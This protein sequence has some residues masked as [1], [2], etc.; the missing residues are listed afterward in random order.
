MIGSAVCF[1]KALRVY[2]APQELAVIYQ[3]TQPAAVFGLVMEMA[4]MECVPASPALDA[5]LTGAGM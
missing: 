2:P 5:M 1:Y 3:K 4:S